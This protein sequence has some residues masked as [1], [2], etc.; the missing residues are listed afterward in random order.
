MP[1]RLC[2]GNRLLSRA[3]TLYR[4]LED[5]YYEA[6]ALVHLGKAW[7]SA[8]SAIAAADAWQQVLRIL[9]QLGHAG[10]E[11]VRAKLSAVS[12]APGTSAERLSGVAD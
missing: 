1:R 9:D 12:A 2:R 10:A 5:R 4:Q 6:D 8:G 7:H 11:K 3:I